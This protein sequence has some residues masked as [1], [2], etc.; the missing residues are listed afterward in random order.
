MREGADKTVVHIY[1]AFMYYIMCELITHIK[2]G[3]P[4]LYLTIIVVVTVDI[5]VRVLIF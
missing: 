1:I 2:T 3:L 4:L 5:H